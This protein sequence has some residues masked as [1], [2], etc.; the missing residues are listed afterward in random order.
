[1]LY[2]AYVGY[3]DLGIE[4]E[5]YCNDFARD[6]I[7]EVDKDSLLDFYNDVWKIDCMEE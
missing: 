7:D 2:E 6:I 1:M 5:R 4:I 3:S